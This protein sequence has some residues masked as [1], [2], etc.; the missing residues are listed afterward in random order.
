MSEQ[1]EHG[2]IQHR[3]S[4]TEAEQLLDAFESSGLRR[5]E[6][7]QQHGVAVGTLDVWRKRRRQERSTLTGKRLR[8]S[9]VHVGKEVAISGR[10]VAV[11][12]AGRPSSGKLTVVLPRGQCVEVFEGFDAATL[13]FA[14]CAGSSVGRVW[15]GAGNTDLSGGRCNG[16]AQ[17]LQRVVRSGARAFAKRATEWACVSVLQRATQSSEADVLGWQWVMGVCEKIGE[18]HVSLAGS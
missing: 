7:C 18:R 1:Q 3:R 16:H 6:F 17:G 13:A 4:R 15:A 10:L 5:R 11:E 14:G 9:K 8:A 12:I 2:K